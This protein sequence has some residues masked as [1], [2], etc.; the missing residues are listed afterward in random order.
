MFF[1]AH[2]GA[3]TAYHSHND[4]GTFVFDHLGERWAMDLGQQTYN[5]VKDSEAYRK[6][7][8]GHNTLTINNHSGFTK[9]QIHLRR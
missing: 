2:A 9:P 3:V 5:V 4:A 8:E 7:T 6:R 1:S